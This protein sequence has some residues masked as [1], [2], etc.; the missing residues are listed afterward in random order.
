LLIAIGVAVALWCISLSAYAVVADARERKASLD[1]LT[2]SL[3]EQLRR[4]ARS[5]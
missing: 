3:S 4:L 2:A 1:A 5:S